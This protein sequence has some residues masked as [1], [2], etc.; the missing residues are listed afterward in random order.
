[1]QQTV[2]FRIRGM[3]CQ[4]CAAR[5]E[6]VLNKKD[7]VEQAEVN[8]AGEDARVVFDN[9]RA[10]EAALIEI[11]R[12]SGFEAETADGAPPQDAAPA[13]PWRLWLLLALWLPFLPGM[14]GM[15]SGHGHHWMLPTVWQWAAA[16]V[17]QFWLAVPFYRSAWAAVKA[18]AANMDV[19]V[20]TGT[21]VIYAYSVWM[22][23]SGRPHQIY[24]EAGVM[25]IGLVSLGKYLELRAKRGSLNSLGLLLQLTPPEA[26]VER[27]GIWQRLPAGDIRRGDLLRVRSGGRIAADGTVVA[28]S[29]WCDESHLTG[30][31]L[32]EEKQSGSRVLAG[33][34]LAN[35]SLTYRAEQL[36]SQT[37]LGDLT[38]ALAEAQ[39]SKAPIARLAD[40]VAAVFVP[41]VLLAALLTFIGNW[42][43]HQDITQ[44]LINAA[45]V[46]VIACPCA[47]GLAT[48]A[49]VMAGIGKA[50]EAGIWFKDAPSLEAASRIDTVILDKTGTLTEGRPQL[51]AIWTAEGIA[52]TDL[53]QMAASLE[54]HAE[55]P[56]ARAVSEAA[57]TRGITLLPVSRVHT[58]SGA[59]LSGHTADGR[60]IRVGTP[61]F[62]GLTLP[63]Q[64]NTVWQHASIAAVAVDGRAWGALALSDAL[65]ADSA[66]AVGRLKKH[67][68]DIYIMS[69]DREGAVMHIAAQLGIT[70]AQGGMSPRDKADAVRR[71][72]AAG[73]RVAMVGDGINDAP[74]LAAADAGF[75]FYSGSGIAVH[76]ATAT[77]MRHS[78]HQLADAL[79]IARATLHTIRQNLFFAFIYNVLG[80][81]L[82]ALGWLNPVIAAAAM[83]LSSLSVIG[84]ALRLKR[85]RIG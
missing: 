24:F 17:V 7:F 19:L 38:T 44:A 40:R 75:A 85:R 32:P 52:E 15:L 33:A 71:L 30:E 60:E 49:A 79:L 14:I 58:E 59:G 23:L 45:A 41:A 50:A 62:C 73:K 64:G 4:A 26:E 56:L 61:A 77:L 22:W 28:G 51:A 65:K 69:G 11:I 13:P 54:A 82:A 67:G 68:I 8:F 27:N 83:S 25:I 78:L 42:L 6:K 72:Q 48:P 53:L 29:G 16:S 66:A 63:E 46:L 39:S 10:D 43:W 21:L 37:L 70:Q 12:K 18:G 74:A 1:M 55:H 34:L 20:G 80:I 36:G 47:L 57:H 3:T 35:G 76:S 9:S 84:N 81:P 31:S 5:I 2:R